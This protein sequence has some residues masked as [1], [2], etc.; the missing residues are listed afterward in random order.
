MEQGE[1]Y[2]KPRIIHCNLTS[3]PHRDSSTV[4]DKL[5]NNAKEY[6]DSQETHV[7]KTSKKTETAWDLRWSKIVIRIKLKCLSQ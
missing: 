3:P 5:K 6:G 4:F 1:G 2:K 7:I